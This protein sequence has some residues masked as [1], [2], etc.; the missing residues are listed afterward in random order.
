MASIILPERKLRE[1]SNTLHELFVPLRGGKSRV[2]CRFA[3]GAPGGTAVLVATDGNAGASSYLE[4]SFRTL[5]KAVRCGYYELWRTSTG[6]TFT[7]DRAYFTLLEVL[8]ATHE[9]R[10]LLC[11]HTDPG[12]DNHLK[13]GPHLHVVC[14]PEPVQHCHFPLEYGFLD[15]VLKD[16][17][18]LTSAMQ[19]AIFIVARDV[20][21]RFQR[22]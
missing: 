18:S 21:P 10:D 7:L 12:D 2:A 3:S 5:T 20:L 1:R 22:S 15:A 17:K 19:R 11:I 8:S 16:C 6:N 14:A 4:E 13:Q 9:Y